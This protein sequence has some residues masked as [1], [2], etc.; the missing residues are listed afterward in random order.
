MKPRLALSMMYFAFLG[1]LNSAHAAGWTQKDGEFYGKVWQRTLIGRE[2]FISGRTT[3]RLPQ[4]YQ[5]HQLNI[6]GEYGLTDDWTLTL[7]GTPLGIA[8]YASD[9]V[10]YTGGA[11]V[12]ARYALAKGRLAA[13]VELQMGGRPGADRRAS[14]IIEASVA[15]TTRD[16][17]TEATP[18]IGTAHASLEVQGGFSTSLLWISGAAGLRAFTNSALKPALFANVQAGWS[19]D[20]GLGLDLRMSL[21]HSTGSIDVI[22]IYGAEQTRY[23]GVGVGMSYWITDN[24]AMNAGVDG[25]LFASANAAT[26]SLMLGI[27]FR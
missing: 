26:P 8:T 5:D 6:Y 16:Q 25:A 4:S 7:S 11:T 14:D 1:P 15:G 9:P 2:I 19:S 18:S 24:F 27:A 17:M 3:A 22:N 21:Y 12:G 10:I 23:L 13:A 20:F